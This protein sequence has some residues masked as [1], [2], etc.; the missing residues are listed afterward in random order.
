MSREGVTRPSGSIPRRSGVAIAAAAVVVALGVCATEAAPRRERLALR[1]V[2]FELPGTPAALILADLD[3]DARSDLLAVVAYSDIQSIGE[4][5]IEGMVQLT[6]VIPALVD[7]RELRA[8]LQQADGSWVSAG[9]AMPLPRSVLALAAGPPGAP[10]YALTDDG[11][12]A[13][14]YDA[15]SAPP[16]RLEP[17]IADRPLVADSGAFLSGLNWSGDVDGDGRDDLWLPVEEGIAIYLAQDDGPQATPSQRLALPGDRQVVGRQHVRS[18]PWPRF[19]DIDGDGRPD[20][21]VNEG[22]G[23]LQ[24]AHVLRGAGGGRFVP[25]DA[26]A[27]CDREGTVLL[28]RAATTD[29]A[30]RALLNLVAV[31][32]LDGDGRAEA[33]GS[34]DLPTKKGGMFAELNEIKRP[35]GRLDVHRLDDTL[36]LEREPYARIDVEGHTDVDFGGINPSLFRDLD[37]DGRKDLISV[38]LDFSVLQGLKIFT[39][40]RFSI[41]LDFHVWNQRADGSFHRV[42][43]LDLSEKMVFDLNDLKLSRLA[44]F[45]GDFDAD[46]RIDFVHLG[47]GR[48]VTIHR[49][50]PGCVYPR[51]PDLTVQLAEEPPDVALVQ[52]RDLD[53]DGRADLAI[54]RPL[55]VRRADVTA[56]VA[57]DLYLSGGA[58]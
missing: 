49:G 9:A 29:P 20:L 30:Q 8:W 22:E 56:P 38:T 44:Q 10:A 43:G 15:S 57:L 6:T 37:G 42:P 18:L 48:N 53:G 34:T 40:K 16:L 2:Q 51:K 12:S 14:R 52:V 27:R 23:S 36:R 13:L 58:P 28:R 26:E 55:P 32:D 19:A 50:Q 25:F 21:I 4:D 5:R 31:L 35:R 3:G 33:I 1:L 17:R 24:A 7:R 54:T 41:G 46:G 45:S 11:V 39:T 47:R